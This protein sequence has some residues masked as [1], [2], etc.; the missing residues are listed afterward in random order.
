MCTT[1]I[2]A[3]AKANPYFERLDTCLIGLSVDSNPSHEAQQKLPTSKRNKVLDSF[4]RKWKI[5]NS[6]H[7]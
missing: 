6:D 5:K 3:F 4:Y 2:I 7:L 1:E